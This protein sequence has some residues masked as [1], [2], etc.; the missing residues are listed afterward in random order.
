M[1]YIEVPIDV[2]GT[3]IAVTSDRAIADTTFYVSTDFRIPSDKLKDYTPTV[4]S[5]DA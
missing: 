3:K 5:T 2:S 1:N 4:S